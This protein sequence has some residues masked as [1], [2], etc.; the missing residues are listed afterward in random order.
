MADAP[1]KETVDSK[2]EQSAVELERPLLSSSQVESQ[3]DSNDAYPEDPAS[4]GECR[5]C[6]QEDSMTNLTQPCAC[7]GS[8]KYAHRECIQAWCNSRQDNLEL[9]CELCKQPYKEGWHIPRP[10]TPSSRSS[11]TTDATEEALTLAEHHLAIVAAQRLL[12]SEEASRHSLDE[13]EAR[14]QTWW[15]AALVAMLLLVLMPHLILVPATSYHEDVPSIM[16]LYTLRML[17]YLLPFYILARAIVVLRLQREHEQV[18]ALVQPVGQH[19]LEQ[20]GAYTVEHVQAGGRVYRQACTGRWA[21][22][23]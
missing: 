23:W 19:T 22:I 10:P 3:V 16:L 12:L 21:H 9:R 18:G 8:L 7:D 6:H 15:R 20:V 1:D 11:D 17:G 2:I 14:I 4:V 5:I 13:Q